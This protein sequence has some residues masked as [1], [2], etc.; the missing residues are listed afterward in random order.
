LTLEPIPGFKL[1]IEVLIVRSGELARRSGVS[2]DTLR[3]YERLRLLPL[4]PR[5]GGGY[6][7]YPEHAIERVGLIRNALSLGFSLGDVKEILEIRDQGGRPCRKTMEVAEAKLEQL[8]QHIQE[9]RRARKQLQLVL[10]DWNL[11]LAGNGR[12][13][14]AKLLENLPGKL[15]S[16]PSRSRR[17]IQP[18]RRT[19]S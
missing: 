13:V 17:G 19:R 5:T 15:K 2:T 6:R 11:R 16:E 1:V 14:L 8:D 3:H 10:K 9:L 7:D 12:G 4:P 18:K